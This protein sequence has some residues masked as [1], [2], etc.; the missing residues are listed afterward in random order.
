MTTLPVRLGAPRFQQRIGAR[1]LS[2]CVA[3]AL[4][5]LSAASVAGQEPGDSL[6][7]PDS[8]LAP[9]LDSVEAAAATD[10]VPESVFYNLPEL[11]DSIPAGWHTGV[12]VWDIDDIMASAANSV[13]DLVAE[14]P[15]V[16]SLL[17]GDYG[18]PAAISAFGTGGGGVRIIRDGFEV[19]PLEGGV[20]DLQR[21]G[22]G[23]IW[24]VKL[25]RSGGEMVVEMWSLQHE[26]GR[27]YTLVEA[28]TG[29][30]DTNIFRGTFAS[31]NAL[32]G[33]LGIALERTDTRGRRREEPGSRT[34]SW[35][36]YQL[37]KGDGAGLA[38]EFRRMSSQSEA[39][40]YAADLA[41]TDVTVRGR[42]SPFSGAV[43]EAY[44]GRSSHKVDDA[45]ALYAREGGT[46]SQHGV[47]GSAARGGAWVR[48]AFRLFGGD[49]SL[50]NRL[51]G[52]AGFARAGLGGVEGH[53]TRA[54]WSGTS[55]RSQGGRGWIE[56]LPGLTLF[57]SWDSGR[58]GARTGP[59]LDVIPARDSTY[60]FD[61]M[62]L[63]VEPGPVLGVTKR[64]AIR[65]GGA[66]SLFG[67]TA[68]AA[69]L[70]VESDVHLPLGIEPDRGAPLV[71]GAVRNGWEVWGSVPMPMN[72]LRLEGS[73]QHWDL[74]GPYLPKRVYRGAFRFRRTFMESGNFELWFSLG[75]R[76][77][78]PMIVSV[79]VPE[80]QDPATSLQT[81]PFFQH[82]YGRIQIRIVSARLFI[83]WENM[84]VRDNLQN[85]PGRLLFATRTSYGIR[86]TMWD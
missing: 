3:C 8:L 71:A 10:S 80:G 49:E 54:N 61:P 9:A 28:G 57:G 7:V 34:G 46:R 84:M 75:V 20:A 21:V 36:R 53:Y 11:T 55:T 27:P 62:V 43:L 67:A 2:G 79:P 47:Q 19:F 13:A 65:G 51:D 4:V 77:H 38:L 41:R 59:P 17:A 16:I 29:D 74:P 40:D 86:W 14:V 66:I 31:P 6:Q 50:E 37:H 42:V 58:Y 18:T 60:V 39:P 82:W 85:F 64:T 44:T 68:S 5:L 72:G 32:G 26:D 73:L 69:L 30:L 12:W 22:L 1:P 15:G 33:S 48:G 25:H 56:P 78:D 52:S 83:N 63:P 45:R 76:G 24:R 23:G 70:R 35:L 81:V